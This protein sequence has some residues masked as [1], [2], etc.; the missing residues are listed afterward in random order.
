[1]LNELHIKHFAIAEHIELDFSS[2]LSVITGETG[3]G[4]S[5]IINA[6]GLVLGQR[7]EASVVKHGQSRAEIQA[8]FDI[9]EQHALKALLVEHDLDEDDSCFLRRVVQAESGSKAYV[10][11]RMVTASLLREIGALLMDIHGQHEHQSL[12]QADTQRQLLDRYAG[13]YSQV[14]QLSEHHRALNLV[15]AELKQLRLNAASQHEKIDFLQ[16][17]VDEL[18]Q[19][20]PRA[21]EWPA[22]HT[23]HQRIHHQAELVAAVQQAE[24]A[25]FMDTEAQ[26]SASAQLAH[27]ITGLETAL[28]IDPALNN[29]RDMLLEAQTLIQESEADIR[30][31]AESSALDETE[32]AQIE[33]RYTGYMEFARKHRIEPEQLYTTF[34]QLQSELDALDNPE[35]NES[36]LLNRIQG[37]ADA[38]HALAQTI[39]QQR[40]YH[41]KKLSQKITEIMQLLAMEGGEF[42][43]EL[44]TAQN[45]F[46]DV[47][48]S[49]A[50]EN[51]GRETGN[52]KVFFKVSTNKG[53]PEQALHKIASG[54]ELS[55]ISLA[56]QV[57]LS[58][59]SEVDTLVFDEVDVGVGGKTAAVIGKMLAQLADARQIL[60]ITHLPQVASF[61]QHHY[62]VHKHQGEQVQLNISALNAQDKISEI[63]RMVG[64]ETITDE[65]LAHARSLIQSS[66]SVSAPKP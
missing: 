23:Q 38:Y 41:A 64:G 56:M 32:M 19:F 30:N 15:V 43:I 47:D 13:I 14:E 42:I 21:D 16:F 60:C 66:S 33:A 62:H 5:I 48:S 34:E 25:L 55:R 63:A 6:L 39:S 59:L 2:G 53:M 52:E 20:S 27:A 50:L 1:M 29:A 28:T 57:I 24:T 61:G 12:L 44:E 65:T 8:G 26:L 7:A 51:I 22:L 17:Q 37:H 11:G 3:A 45:A 10:N 46:G 49:L 31:A 4:K 40:Q 54:G 58:D 18:N 35:Q 36:T 9:R